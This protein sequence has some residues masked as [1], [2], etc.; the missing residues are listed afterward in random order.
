MKC[1][2]KNFRKKKK[3]ERV[4]GGRELEGKRRRRE[5]KIYKPLLL[6]KL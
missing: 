5:K 6:F 1:R 4:H 2:K 3:S